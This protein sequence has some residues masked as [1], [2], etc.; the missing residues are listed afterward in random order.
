MFDN[1]FSKWLRAFILFV[2]AL[3][4]I[5]ACITSIRNA[6]ADE[7]ERCRQYRDQVE[8]ILR[9]EAVSI[10]Y[11]YLMAAE[12]RCTDKAVSVKGASGFWQLMPATA[13]HYGCTD[14]HNLEC[15]T[16]AAA[17]YIRHLQSQFRRFD[18]VIMAY[19]MGGHN[20]RRYGATKEARGLLYTVKR[21]M[22]NDNQ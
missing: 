10:D 21:M 14:L 15:S 5:G 17:R 1:L 20:Y 16:R 19:N 3:I 2:I 11:Y 12:S 6:N 8:I 7:L 13:K 22:K 4:V 18:D 9:S